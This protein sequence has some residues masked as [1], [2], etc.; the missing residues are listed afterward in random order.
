MNDRWSMY[1]S[2]SW[3]AESGRIEV[4]GVIVCR[5]DDGGY[6][7]LCSVGMNQLAH[8]CLV[9]RLTGLDEL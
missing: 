3:D 2:A 5:G 4:D 9:N 8:H 6:H 7:Q 1:T